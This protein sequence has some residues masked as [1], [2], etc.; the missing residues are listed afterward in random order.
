MQKQQVSMPKTR[1]GVV[2]QGVRPRKSFQVGLRSFE[3]LGFRVWVIRGFYQVFSNCSIY[4][5]IIIRIIIRI[6]I[7]I[8]RI[9]II[10][11]IIMIPIIIRIIIIL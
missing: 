5:I 3:Q 2:C 6:I 9:K 1:D 7:M 10:R 4:T 8:I 11:I